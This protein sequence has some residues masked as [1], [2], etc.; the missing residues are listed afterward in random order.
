MAKDK[1]Q[2]TDEDANADFGAGFTDPTKAGPAFVEGDGEK[3]DDKGEGDEKTELSSEKAEGTG[4][5]DAESNKD[6]EGS[7]PPDETVTLTKSQLDRLLAAADKAE[8]ADAKFEK[9]FGTTGDL[10][11]L[12]KNL[13]DATPKGL[14]VEIPADAF[15]ELEE[16]YP[17]LAPKLRGALEKSLAG[18]KG[19]GDEKPAGDDDKKGGALKPE[20]VQAIVADAVI[21]REMVV[22]TDE[23]P[24]WRKEV[25]AIDPD[26]GEKPDPK[27]PF[28]V[29]LSAQPESYRKKVNDTDSP[30]VV[31]KALD[32][33]K[34]D[35]K[36]KADKPKPPPKDKKAEA[37]EGRFE[38]AVQPKGDG[39]PPP[40]RKTDEDHFNDGF[41]YRK[42]G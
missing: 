21:R 9:L 6:K 34:A 14:K 42:S 19:T 11:S 15:K 24:E 31:S 28:R 1:D 22:L 23:H 41:N 8:G 17:D 26:K 18:V 30:L 5:T 10:K 38:D 40:K 4:D 32:K 35:Q 20:A 3:S 13:Q 27:H 2:Y 25:N 7:P 39:N 37:R 12:V 36:A 29:W 33:F 16:E